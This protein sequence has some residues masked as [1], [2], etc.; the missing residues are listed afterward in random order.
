VGHSEALPAE[1]RA[2]G[3]AYRPT[4]LTHT[5]NATGRLPVT[6]GL[7]AIGPDEYFLQTGDTYTEL[8]SDSLAIHV[9]PDMQRLLLHA[10]GY[11]HVVL[12]TDCTSFDFP[13]PPEYAHVTD[14][15]FDEMGTLAG[16]RL[17]MDTA[18]RNVMAHTNCG[19]A[20]AFIMASLAP[21][22]AVGLDRERGSIER[23]KIAD[24]VFVDDRFNVK[25]VVLGGE[26]CNFK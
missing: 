21:A 10:K 14:L 22:R 24:L 6:P 18:C 20:Q 5:F 23:G 1:I 3:T 15:S 7:R 25:N 19:I 4:I 13:K 12:I 2:L 11:E 26:L 16:S 8:I 17:T 9:A